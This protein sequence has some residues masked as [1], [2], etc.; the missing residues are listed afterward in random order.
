RSMRFA[1][2]IARGKPGQWYAV[3]LPSGRQMSTIF[4]SSLRAAE[5]AMKRFHVDN[6]NLLREDGFLIVPCDAPPDK[7]RGNSL[8]HLRYDI[9]GGE[10]AQ[11][12]MR[13]LGI[14]YQY[15]VPQSMGDCWWFFN[16]ENVPDPLPP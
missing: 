6:W 11:A 15:A 4:K 9:Y 10:H 7:N 14:T 2:G 3:Q 1:N 5:H 8:M 12:A 16:C 13:R